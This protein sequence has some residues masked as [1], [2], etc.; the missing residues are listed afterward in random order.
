MVLA[1]E[2]LVALKVVI[3]AAMVTV[4]EAAALVLAAE[5]ADTLKADDA[6][7]GNSGVAIVASASLVA[8]GGVINSIYLL[9]T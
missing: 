7:G 6:N 4:A 1:A 9:S 3:V 2:A 8:R 5:A